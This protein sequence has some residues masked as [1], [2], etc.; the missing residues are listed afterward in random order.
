MNRKHQLK[1]VRWHSHQMC[2]FIKT[3]LLLY[4][5]LF[6]LCE[7]IQYHTYYF[8]IFEKLCKS[9]T[10][11]IAFVIASHN[12]MQH[13]MQ[14]W[15]SFTLIIYKSNSYKIALNGI[16]FAKEF[17]KKLAKEFASKIVEMIVTNLMP[18]MT[19]ISYLVYLVKRVLDAYL[20]NL[21]SCSI[22]GSSWHCNVDDKQT[23]PNCGKWVCMTC[24]LSF[25][26]QS[27]LGPTWSCCSFN[28]HSSYWSPMEGYCIKKAKDDRYIDMDEYNKIVQPEFLI[29]QCPECKEPI[30]KNLG[31]RFMICKTCKS[32][33]CWDCF[34]LNGNCNCKNN[35][36]IYY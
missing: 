3:M 18:L 7:L 4:I 17:A 25:T 14:L 27:P 15:R 23:C 22:Q 33:F 11:V 34:E 21:K 13:Y 12:I 9:S 16:L 19:M 10:F 32:N 24:S 20:N 35:I 6:I 31:C 26:K 5:D 29:K 28:R 2:T 1:P 30:Q 36:F 8:E